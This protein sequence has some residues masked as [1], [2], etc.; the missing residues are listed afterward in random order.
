M[1]LGVSH[2]GTVRSP[3]TGLGG[4]GYV[5][6]S[7]WCIRVVLIWIETQLMLCTLLTNFSALCF[8]ILQELQKLGLHSS[9]GRFDSM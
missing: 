5:L 1:Q 8:H 4:K 3:C 9:T 7:T 6:L 2:V